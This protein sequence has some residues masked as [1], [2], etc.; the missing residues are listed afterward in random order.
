M[1]AD[2][3]K[4]VT[5][6]VEE[7]EP[8]VEMTPEQMKEK[9]KELYTAGKKD[10]YEDNFEKAADSLA[11]AAQ[12]ADKLFGQKAGETFDYYLYYG[13]AELE[14]GRQENILFRNAQEGMP[15]KDD[16]MCPAD[17]SVLTEGQ[18]ET[19]K[20]QVEEAL[21]E[22]AK[23][24]EGNAKET[25]KTEEDTTNEADKK[26]SAKE[27]ADDGA[28]G[29]EEAEE[30]EEGVDGEDEEDEE[31][32]EPLQSAWE[33]FEHC[34][35]IC[36]NQE[37]SKD[38][39]LKLADVLTHLGDCSAENSNF[40]QGIEDLCK[41]QEL[42]EKHGCIGRRLADVFIEMARVYKL[43][44]NFHS[45]IQYYEKAKATLEKQIGILEKEVND[46]SKKETAEL[47]AIAKDLQGL[48]EDAIESAKQADMVKNLAGD[49]P[50][51]ATTK[52]PSAP[53][54]GKAGTMIEVRKAP[55]RPASSDPSEDAENVEAK[56]LKETVEKEKTTGDTADSTETPRENVDGSLT[57]V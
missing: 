53:L 39:D 30:A 46:E 20:E 57:A 15:T 6:V 9:L 49:Q 3:R 37:K 51:T 50:A 45:A 25:N 31:E 10:Y 4:E 35:L 38:W 24:L 28:E 43:A 2:E 36:E 40:E 12:L 19:I 42:K 7:A 34:R 21:E 14:I 52:I 33:I 47:G 1:V 8:D 23:E 5:E 16:S 13:R 29:D 22:N 27:T 44:D 17:A 55:K 41:A 18:L 32:R 48:L 11:E 54:D 56:K 26:E